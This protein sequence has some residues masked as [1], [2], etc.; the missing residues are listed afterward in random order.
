MQNSLVT[1]S[2]PM[3]TENDQLVEGVTASVRTIWDCCLP[4]CTK[5]DTVIL[6]VPVKTCQ[7]DEPSGMSSDPD[8]CRGGKQH[9]CSN[10]QP[11]EYNGDLA[12]SF[13]KV[14]LP[15]SE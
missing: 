4:S 13:A 1:E 3:T 12:F 6:K 11:I 10:L 8:I 9:M 15:V 5:F 14:S 7:I 2:S